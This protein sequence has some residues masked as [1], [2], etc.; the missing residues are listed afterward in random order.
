MV[1]ALLCCGLIGVVYGFDDDSDENH[2]LTMSCEYSAAGE[3][4][5][6]SQDID[7]TAQPAAINVFSAKDI[8]SR[9]VFTINAG[10]FAECR[11]PSGHR[12]RVKVGQGLDHPYGR[13]GGDPDIFMSMWVNERKLVSRLWF[14]GHCSE[15]G[16]SP[17]SGVSFRIG[18]RNTLSVQKCQTASPQMNATEEQKQTDEETLKACVDF[19][20]VQAFPRDQQEYPVKGHKL[21][22]PGEVLLLSGSAKVC[23]VVWREIKVS[24]NKFAN[25]ADVKSSQ[26]VEPTWH[27]TTVN[28]L[29]DQTGGTPSESIF[30]IDNDGKLDK[31]FYFGAER[32]DFDG[33][34]M[35]I[36]KGRLASSFAKLNSRNDFTGCQHLIIQ[37]E[38]RA[39]PAFDFPH[40]DGALVLKSAS[41][42]GAL[43]FSNQLT[44]LSPFRW[45]GVSYI[46]VSSRA[47]DTLNYVAV[48][49]PLPNKHLQQM[50]LFKQVTENF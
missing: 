39:C 24:F 38:S 25:Y 45:Q 17:G 20:N 9:A 33:S 14:A 4:V 44:W 11:Y 1:V 15:D 48:M 12:V 34:V 21:P 3:S 28:M 43:S 13:C 29:E 37:Y 27:S 41:E 35:F 23:Q 18:G 40:G 19:P 2:A 5:L 31:V 32:N 50:C 6:V 42:D 36:E 10:E 26:L 49:K 8:G 30:D 16:Q 46:G 22:V 47:E 7:A